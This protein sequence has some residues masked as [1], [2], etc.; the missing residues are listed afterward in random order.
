MGGGGD[1]GGADGGGGEGGGGHGEGGKL[2]GGGEGGKC[3]ERISYAVMYSQQSK[4][5]YP[6][7]PVQMPNWKISNPHSG[8]GGAPGD[9]GGGSG[10][11]GGG[12]DSTTPSVTPALLS[13]LWEY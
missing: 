3:T 4:Q 11:G 12:G 2:G 10:L 13:S 8:V 5:A 7:Q 6:R 1:G 9:G